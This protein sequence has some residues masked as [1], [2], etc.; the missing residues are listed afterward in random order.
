MLNKQK[1]HGNTIIA[2]QQ[3]RIATGQCM[4]NGSKV[5]LWSNTVWAQFEL[6]TLVFLHFLRNFHSH[7]SAPINS[8]AV[9]FW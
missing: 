1:Q 7:I 5:N 8:N 2:L 3:K 4:E 6:A 9:A